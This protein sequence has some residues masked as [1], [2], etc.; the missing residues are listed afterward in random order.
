MYVPVTVDLG[1]KKVVRG[2]KVTGRQSVIDLPVL[3]WN[4]A[5]SSTISTECWRTSR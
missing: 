1:D 3:P 2:V 4:P 5:S